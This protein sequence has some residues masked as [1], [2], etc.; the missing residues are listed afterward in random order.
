MIAVTPLGPVG[1]IQRVFN[2]SASIILVTNVNSS[3]AVRIQPSRIDG[4]LEGRGDN[5]GYLKYVPQEADVKVGERVVTSGL[6]GIYPEGL[7]V[8]DVTSVKKVGRELFQLIEVALAQN[9]NTIEEVAIYK[10]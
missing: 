9:L 2:D 7:L 8:G 5:R 4:I 10:R 3:I 6:D 1:R